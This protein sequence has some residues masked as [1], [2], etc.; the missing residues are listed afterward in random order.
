MIFCCHPALR[1]FVSEPARQRGL[2]TASW[3]MSRAASIH[4]LRQASSLGDWLPTCRQKPP[5]AQVK[6]TGGV[7]LTI[8][9]LTPV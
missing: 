8:N 3:A 5:G 2:A 6:R 7:R 9:P 4:Q 1:P